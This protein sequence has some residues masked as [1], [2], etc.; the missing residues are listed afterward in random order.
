MG[1]AVVDDYVRERDHHLNTIN[2]LTSTAKERGADPSDEDLETIDKLKL[3]MK[4]LDHLIDVLG[5]DLEMS[6]ETRNK[7]ARMNPGSVA[8]APHYRSAGELVWDAIHATMGPQHDPDTDLAQKR[9]G[10]VLKR[11]AEHMGTD[12]AKTTPVAGGLGG[13][14][15]APVVG[16]VIDLYPSSQPFLTGIGMRPAPNSLTFIRPRIVDPDFK[17]GAGIQALQKAELVSKK[18][19]VK[20]DNLNLTTVGGY[21]NV[22]QQ[23]L[24]FQ[25]SGLDII[26][27][28][29]QKRVAY[30][31]E[32]AGIAELSKTTATVPLADPTDPKAVN[33]AVFAAAALVYQNT[34][35]LP[36]WIAFGPLGWQM[37]GSLTDAAG[38]PLFPFLG[39][40]N[41]MGQ[42]SA[43]SFGMTG[44]AG[45]RPIITPAITDDSLFV[46]NALGLEGYRYSFPILEAIEPALLGRQVAVAEAL[47]F[48]RPTTTEAD[49]GPPVVEQAGNGAVK[50]VVG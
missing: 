20:I 13:L 8:V 18:F 23:L 32:A 24:S 38:R 27:N 26:V 30:Q 49:A 16:P 41:A 22:S 28:Q 9:Y 33:E 35:E 48:Y 34:G 37:L 43:D 14:Y 5:E 29:L 10:L 36:S 21:L 40:S 19:D 45:L 44:P 15:V 4:R 2:V 47:T 12:A 46:G 3:R 31:G 7:L 25:P 17:T 6:D 1:N 50:I 42:M 39:A 11:A